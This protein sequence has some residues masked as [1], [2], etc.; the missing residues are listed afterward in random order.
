MENVEPETKHVLDARMK[1]DEAE[2]GEVNDCS[3]QEENV[4]DL[5]S[6]CSS[7]K[8]HDHPSSKPLNKV[9][10]SETLSDKSSELLTVDIL[11]EYAVQPPSCYSL[12]PA[13]CTIS[14]KQIDATDSC[15]RNSLHGHASPNEKQIATPKLPSAF[16]H[17]KHSISHTLE[18]VRPSHTSASVQ[19]PKD[20]LNGLRNL[21][22]VQLQMQLGITMNSNNTDQ[23]SIPY[24]GLSQSIAQN[25]CSGLIPNSSVMLEQTTSTQ[26]I[27]EN[28]DRDDRFMLSTPWQVAAPPPAA[29]GSKQE[30][31]KMH[32]MYQKACQLY[33]RAV[34]TIGSAPN[35]SIQPP[36]FGPSIAGSTPH[37]SIQSLPNLQIPVTIIERPSHLSPSTLISPSQP[38]QDIVREVFPNHCVDQNSHLPTPTLNHSQSAGYSMAYSAAYQETMKFMSGFGNN[39]VTNTSE[40]T[41]QWHCYFNHYL[42][43][44]LQA[45]NAIPTLTN[46]Q[47]P[48]L[49]PTSL[50]P[51]PPP[52]DISSISKGTNLKLVPDAENNHDSKRPR[53]SSSDI[54]S[55]DLSLPH[56]EHFSHSAE[57]HKADSIVNNVSKCDLSSSKCIWISNLPQ[58]VRAVD[59]K[60]M[61]SPYGKVQTIKIVG[62]KKSTPP[63]IYAYLIMETSEAAIRLVH[64]LQGVKFSENELKVRQINPIRLP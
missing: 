33:Q 60:E 14:S 48:I 4:S 13:Q 7:S 44:F 9:G 6:N 39:L 35:V 63:S 10:A 59:V 8:S 34:A 31:E 57:S 54:L 21:E 20:P 25:S 16:D 2:E 61:C 1:L 40:Y 51:P 41:S 15:K 26:I 45:H 46:N 64:G 38:P 43:Y 23:P 32:V 56:S 58:G 47:Q 12:Q 36:P 19:S 53:L 52:S 24:P 17:M 27:S 18:Q 22:K 28:H 49:S 55:S 42:N 37:L 5:S 30:I 3:D 11:R 50:P 29:S 62:S